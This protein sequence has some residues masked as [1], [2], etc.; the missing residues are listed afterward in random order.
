M[1]ES[2]QEKE[3]SEGCGMMPIPRARSPRRPAVC[4]GSQCVPIGGLSHAMASKV[5]VKDIMTQ[6]GKLVTCAPT[7]KV[8][9]AIALMVKHK[10]SGLPVIDDKCMVEGVV[11][12][13]DV[14]LAR[15]T[16]NVKTVMTHEIVAIGPDATPREAAELLT[17]RKVKRA[18]VLK[19]DGTLW[20]VISRADILRA[21]A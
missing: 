5:T 15:R 20:G 16:T 9:D 19:P 10:V 8:A 7:A 12:E 21:L 18:I 17:S 4:P 3:Q 11:T 2:D 14:L 1:R 6:G 13:A